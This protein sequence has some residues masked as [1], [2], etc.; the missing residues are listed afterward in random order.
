MS[1]KDRA[2]PRMTF[3]TALVLHA[4]LADPTSPRYGLEVAKQTRLPTGTIYPILARLEA[5][6]WVASD[7]EAV[8]PAREGRPR[9]RL[10]QLTGAGATQARAALSDMRDRLAPTRIVPGGT[11]LEPRGDSP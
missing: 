9:R 7:W 2:K 1:N 6:G 11:P 5:A 10:Y 8:E 3:Q 4:L